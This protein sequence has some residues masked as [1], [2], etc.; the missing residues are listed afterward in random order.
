MNMDQGKYNPSS[1]L[2]QTVEQFAEKYMDLAIK[3]HKAIG[4][5]NAYQLS[6]C[7]NLNV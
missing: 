7:L 2:S 3:P 6:N 4:T 5:I 1:P